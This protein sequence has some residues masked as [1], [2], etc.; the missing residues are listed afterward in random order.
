MSKYMKKIALVAHEFGLFKGRGG[1]A[2]YLYHLS[3]GFLTSK[4]LGDEDIEVHVIAIMCDMKSDLLKYNNFYIHP[5]L[6]TGL[7]QQGEFVLDKLKEIK[8][9]YVET[10]DAFAFCLEA[11]LYKNCCG[12]ELK[13]TKFFVIHHTATRECFEWSNKLALELAPR[14]I[15]NTYFR[16]KAQMYLADYNTFPADF[17]KNYVKKNY[18]IIDG[19]ILRYTYCGIPKH[20]REIIADIQDNIDLS[21]YEGKFVISY[22]SRLEGRKNQQLLV[23]AFVEFLN[24]RKVDAILILAGNSL[25]DKITEEDE[26]MKIYK[27]IP[28][29]Y[30]KKIKFLDFVDTNTIEKLCAITDLTVMTSIFENFPFAMIEN[31]YRGIPIMTSRYNGC[32][33]IMGD[34]AF[35][36][37]FDP[38]IEEDLIH[39]ITNFYDMSKEEREKVAQIQYSNMK[40]FCK[41]EN[42]IAEKIK[43][44]DSFNASKSKEKRFCVSVS[45]KDLSQTI[46]KTQIGLKCDIIICQNRIKKNIEKLYDWYMLAIERAGSDLTIVFG[47]NFGQDVDVYEALVNQ[48]IIFVKDVMISEKWKNC[49]YAQLISEELLKR[50]EFAYIPI[51]NGIYESLVDR[52][53]KDNDGTF[54]PIVAEMLYK[55]KKLCMKER[56]DEK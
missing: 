16:E 23:N 56:Y 17:L 44:F 32:V 37:S 35:Q 52:K 12:N 39:K 36:M 3:K 31:V 13:N 11:I 43:F 30:R 26:R 25:V 38:Y 15:K 51:E 1:I 47:H 29:E 8:P 2:T 6:C 50:K 9:D 40:F 20:K 55:E 24:R 19:K 41:P 22:I 21:L 33:D 48:R 49:S 18:G 53:E 34:Y 4:V 7:E 54:M 42:S 45:Q 14:H 5:I 46:S 27:T 28:I 10:A